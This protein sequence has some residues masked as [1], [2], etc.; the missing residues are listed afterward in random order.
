MK[1]STVVWC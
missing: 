1:R